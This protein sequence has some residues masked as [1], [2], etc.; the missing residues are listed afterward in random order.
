MTIDFEKKYVRWNL[1]LIGL[2]IVLFFTIVVAITIGSVGPIGSGNPERIPMQAVWDIL[3]G[4]SHLWPDSYKTIIMDI[5][6]PRILLAALVGCALAVSGVVMQGI[7]R[8]PMVDPFIIGLS[9]GAAVGA[10]ISILLGLSISIGIYSTPFL[11]FVGAGLT[12]F[13][14]YFIARSKGKVRVE[15]LL[16]TGIATGSFLT[17]VTSFLMYM[18][19]EQFRF[20]FFWLLGGL[21]K[22]SWNTVAIAFSLILLGVI[23]IQF[24]AKDLNAMLLGEEP[25]MHLGIDT[26][27]V[28]NIL[29]IF[30][31]L[32]VGTAVAFTGI[33]GFVGLITPHIMRILVGPNHRILLPAS[34]LAG[35]IFLIWSDT[36]ARTILSPTEIPVGI[37]TAFCGAPFFVYLLQK[38]K[39]GKR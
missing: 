37:I 7:F 34:A 11:A 32:V 8:N 24:F 13:G 14:V 3:I 2:L 27:S 31:S 20:L 5:R 1:I 22:A 16:L 23:I 10:S 26:G 19:N 6:L 38:S 35:A 25:A 39:K 9:S 12:V 21:N 15:T 36:I 18:A 4:K 17:A 30:S 28:K 33:I 29:L